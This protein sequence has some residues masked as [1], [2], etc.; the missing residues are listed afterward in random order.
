MATEYTEEND[1]IIRLQPVDT[2]KSAYTTSYSSVASDEIELDDVSEGHLRPRKNVFLSGKLLN[3]RN[4]THKSCGR[5]KSWKLLYHRLVS[6]VL[7][8]TL[9]FGS[10]YLFILMST[11]P[12]AFVSDRGLV[13]KPNGNFSLSFD[14]YTPWRRDGIFAINMRLGNFDFGLAKVIDIAW[15]IVSFSAL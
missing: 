9:L 7:P 2:S 11:A 12:S 3:V 14:S 4:R 6:R 8:A 13:C 5:E 1:L 10:L 15:D